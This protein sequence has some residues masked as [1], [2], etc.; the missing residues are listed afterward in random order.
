MPSLLGAGLAF[1]L[2]LTA[3]IADAAQAP[4]GTI[5]VEVA[6]ATTPMAGAL[7]S[8]GGQSATTD[9]SGIATLALPPGPVSVVASKN[10]YAPATTRVDVVAG[11]EHA[12]RMV[13]TANPTATDQVP[14]ISSTRTGRRIDD[15]AVAVEVLSRGRIEDTMLMAPGDIVRSLDEMA[16]LRVQSTS[17]ELGLT[18]VRIRGLRGQYTRLLSDGV[19]LHFDLPGGLAPVQIPAIGLERIEVIAGGA[20]ALFGANALGGVVNLLSRRP[21]KDPKREF[22]VSQSSRE[23]TDVALWLASAQTGSWGRTLLVSG[24]RQNEADVDDDGWSD[25][26]EYSRGHVRQR[27]FWNN[28]R[29]R[30]ASGTAG[31]TFE[32]REGGSAIARQALETKIADGALFGQ[33]P[34]GRYVL[35]GAGSLYVQ[36]RDRQFSDRREHE[37]RQ[38]ATIEIGLHGTAPRQAWVVGVAADWFANR[39]PGT[40]AAGY[41]AP[42]GGIFF[43]D[44]LRVAPWLLVSGSARLDY[45]KGAG[46]VLRINEFFAS[47][48]GSVLARKGAWGVRVSAGRSYFVP[49]TLTEETE[50]AGFAR[51]TI[52]DPIEIETARNVSADLSYNRPSAAVV[53][54]VFDTRVDDPAVIDRASYT[55]RTDPE[56]LTSRGV[57]VRGSV[58]RAPF[59]LGV[60]YAFV[61]AREGGGRDVALTPR[62]N[63][64]LVAS[65]GSA[66]GRV[67]VQADYTGVQ[68]LDRNPYR[69]RS[70]PYTVLSLLSEVRF[71]RW[72]LFANGENLSDERQTR[73]DPIARPSRD[74]DG[75]WTVDA[76][77]PLQGR[78]IN[79]GIRVSF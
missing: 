8:A 55:L 53:V 14:V 24:H 48:R 32:K 47:P 20:S 1:A 64:G 4:T 58:R 66:R 31:V 62:H 39:S 40:P 42:R 9:A 78:V 37:R 60:T 72:R 28:R 56:P 11:A 57:E 22:L 36:S 73:W 7:V 13:L 30:S 16:S 79:G 50:A 26:P 3:R 34:F 38:A 2:G 21:D 19:P 54:T 76:W 46:E 15:Q 44:D 67:S 68:R 23:T 29:G 45:N 25:L 41:I 27:V 77:A 74:V 51:L 63:A 52:D 33:M 49:T 69:S 59:S 6:D 12:L 5:R 18:T 61:R 43:H 70:E 65:V 75:R 35:A 17:P 10:G 71:G